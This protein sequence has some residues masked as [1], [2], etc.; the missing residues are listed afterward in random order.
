MTFE[1]CIEC[2]TPVNAS[3]SF[4]QSTCHQLLRWNLPHNDSDGFPIGREVVDYITPIGYYTGGYQER[5][6][7]RDETRF[8][9]LRNLA[10]QHRT[11]IVTA[12][13]NRTIELEEN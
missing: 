5:E 9:T 10:M 13:Q 4:C 1:I 3:E 7:D 2:K 11:R 12:Q 8:E 6:R